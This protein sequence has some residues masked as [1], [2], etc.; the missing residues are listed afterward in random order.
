[1][2]IMQK[3]NFNIANDGINQDEVNVSIVE[4]EEEIEVKEV[5]QIDD[6]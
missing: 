4:D 1:M 2:E 5:K 3:S 6:V